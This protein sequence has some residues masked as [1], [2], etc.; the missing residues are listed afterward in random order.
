VLIIIFEATAKQTVGILIP[1]QH[2]CSPVRRNQLNMQKRTITNR[3]AVLIKFLLDR[4]PGAHK[5]YKFPTEVTEMD[6]G[7]MGSLL[8]NEYSDRLFGQDLIQA[9]YHDID[10]TLVLVTLTEDNKQDLFELDMW[11]VDNSSLKEFPTPDKLF[12]ESI[13]EA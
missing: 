2:K 9:Q 1:Q 13:E 12:F 8:L 10:G 3:E 7:G 6:D 4:I 5:Q 11:K